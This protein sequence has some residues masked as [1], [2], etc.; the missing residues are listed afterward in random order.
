MCVARA[1]H[2]RNMQGRT[3]FS[4]RALFRRKTFS[5][6]QPPNIGDACCYVHYLVAMV[7]SR[8]AAHDFAFDTHAFDQLLMRNCIF[9]CVA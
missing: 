2:S 6:W 5:V 4:Y 9:A 3:V 1:H 7:P 8:R